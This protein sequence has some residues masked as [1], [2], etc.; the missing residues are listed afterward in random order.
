[1]N[2][3]N[4]I[5]DRLIICFRYIKQAFPLE[6]LAKPLKIVSSFSN[7]ICLKCLQSLENNL[8]IIVVV[9]A[10]ALI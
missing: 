3:E 4:S 9:R 8:I 6:L 1:M 5:I 2:L 10:F 7:D